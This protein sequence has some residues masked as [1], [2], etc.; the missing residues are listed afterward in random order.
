MVTCRY[1]S[2][3]QPL[4]QISA[5]TLDRPLRNVREQAFSGQCRRASAVGNA[6]RCGVPIRALTD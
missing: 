3:R 5:A 2:M 6:I 1:Q 4:K